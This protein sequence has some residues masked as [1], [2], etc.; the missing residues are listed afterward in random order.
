MP[1]PWMKKNPFMSMWPSGANSVA[2]R[3]RVQATAAITKHVA[4]F[5]SGARKAR[6]TKLSSSTNPVPASGSCLLQIETIC[7]QH[8]CR[9]RKRWL[10]QKQRR[11][12]RPQRNIEKRQG[13]IW[14]PISIV[15][16]T[17]GGPQRNSGQAIGAQNS[18]ALN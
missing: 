3:A 16:S 7:R 2:G 5:W 11:S 10:G 15:W 14:T 13:T 12:S 6:K 18:S 1:N 17:S 9:E 8:S 4:Q